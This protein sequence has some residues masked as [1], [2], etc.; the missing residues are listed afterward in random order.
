MGFSTKHTIVC[1]DS[2]ND[3]DMLSGSSR[4]IVVANAEPE[5]KQWMQHQQLASEDGRVFIAS[6]NMAAGIMEGIEHFGF[7]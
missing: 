1:G 7:L 3:K 2:G 5:L 4:A 6:N